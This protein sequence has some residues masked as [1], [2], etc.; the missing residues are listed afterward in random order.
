MKR[1]IFLILLVCA[2]VWAYFWYVRGEN[3]I[4]AIIGGDKTVVAEPDY[5]YAR[6]KDKAPH[7]ETAAP[8]I[9]PRVNVA[10]VAVGEKIYVI[11]GNDAYGRTVATV[12]AFDVKTNSWSRE[13]DLPKALHHVTASTDGTLIYVFGGL[14]GIA[15]TPVESTFIFNPKIGAWT[16]GPDRGEAVGASAA[17]YIGG[18]FHVLGG[19][20]L[21]SSVQ[22]HAIYDPVKKQWGAG[23]P[24]VSGRDHLSAEAVGDRLYAIGGRAG[25]LVYN[26]N[27]VESIDQA[28]GQWEQ[29]EKLP[30]NRSAHG[31][32]YIGGKLYVFGGEAST[33]AF[34]DMFV[35]DI[36]LKRWSNGTPMPTPRHGFGYATVD[37]RIYVF[38]GGR[39]PG[40]SVS[41]LSEVFTPAQ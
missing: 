29:S 13:A 15:A 1:Y 33:Q 40:Y 3:L 35:F 24:L 32:A 38:G 2:T 18:T 39:R 16:K 7:W 14:K 26:L 27:D 11:G 21:G 28:G 12:E 8:M 5:L 19:I 22:I 10:A 36:G 31:S 23:E 37:G 30:A 25:S 4:D 17:A 34:N 20:G 41:D 9:A 6:R